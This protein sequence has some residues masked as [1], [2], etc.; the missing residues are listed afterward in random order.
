AMLDHAPETRGVFDDVTRD[1][2]LHLQAQ[3]GVPGT[4]IVDSATREVLKQPRCGHPDG[5]AGAPDEKF[6]PD[7]FWQTSKLT[8]RLLNADE[9]PLAQARAAISA[10][11]ATWAATTSLSFEE[12]GDDPDIQLQFE[13][14]DGVGLQA[15]SA[16]GPTSGGDVFFD[17]SDA[18]SAA[19]PTPLGAADVETIALHEIGHT[20]GLRHSSIAGATMRPSYSAGTQ[21]RSLDADDRLALSTLY[22]T[23]EQ[24]PGCHSDIGIDPGPVASVW[25]AGCD[26][27]TNGYSVRKWNGSSWDVATGNQGAVRI[28]VQDP[29]IP[30]IVDALGNIYRRTTTSASSGDWQRVPGC[31]RDIGAG[32]DFMG[33]SVWIIGCDARPG[34]FAV[35]AWNGFGFAPTLDN[36]GGQKVA[37]DG[38][39]APYIVTSSGALYRRNSN[40]SLYGAWSEFRDLNNVSAGATDVAVYHAYYPWILGNSFEPDGFA[41]QVWQEQGQIDGA[42]MAKWWRRVSRAGVSLAMYDLTTPWITDGAGALFK[43]AK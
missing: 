22:D 5:L 36:Q 26:T 23:W 24:L 16:F 31:A 17:S 32:G 43:P 29:G 11:F 39:G 15:A 35:H 19:S 38:F 14:L 7:E 3:L 42:R 41:L 37:V 40:S 2:V 21:D 28:S 13:T 25:T 8:W 33:G 6:Y 1:A 12:T 27:T 9:V 18:W 30:W 10:A 34:G 4:G 20:L